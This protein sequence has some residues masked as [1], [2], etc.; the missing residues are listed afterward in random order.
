MIKQFYL[1]HGWEPTKY[2]QLVRVNLKVNGNEGILHIPQSLRLESHH[3]I[4][5]M[6]Y[7]GDLSFVVSFLFYKTMKHQL[8]EKDFYF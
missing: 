1:T 4:L 8:Y 3:Q 7:P 2:Y 6:S 5:L